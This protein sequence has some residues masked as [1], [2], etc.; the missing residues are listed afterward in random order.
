MLQTNQNAATLRDCCL[1]LDNSLPSKSCSK[2][3]GGCVIMKE[4][5]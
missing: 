1:L 3:D 2:K 4:N 5:F